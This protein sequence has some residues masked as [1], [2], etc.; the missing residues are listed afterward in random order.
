MEPFITIEAPSGISGSAF[1]TVK[2]V[3]LTL[4]PNVWSKWASVIWPSGTNSP[5]P[6][7]A[8]RTSTRPFCSHRRVQSIQIRE[9]GNVPLDA[10]DVL[11]DL[12]HRGVELGVTATGDED[13]RAFRDEPLCSGEADSAVASGDDR[14]FSFQ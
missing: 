9:I 4:T 5:R 3:P 1:C 8:K 2:S 6:A 11:A 14:D 7:L 10:A 13:V 12:A